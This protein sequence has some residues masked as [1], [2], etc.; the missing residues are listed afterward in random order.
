MLTW[1]I[2]NINN[3]VIAEPG[4]EKCNFYFMQYNSMQS[5]CYYYYYLLQ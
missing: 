5:A 3:I 4:F 1:V 2:L